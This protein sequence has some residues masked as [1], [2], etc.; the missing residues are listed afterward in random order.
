MLYLDLESEL[1]L[2]CLLQCGEA[3]EQIEV[4]VVCHGTDPKKFSR[5]LYVLM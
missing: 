5:L 3:T 1:C 2:G 4:C